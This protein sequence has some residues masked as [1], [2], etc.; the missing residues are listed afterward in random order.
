ML[1]LEIADRK[2]V[3]LETHP[4]KIQPNK[5]NIFLFIEILDEMRMKLYMLN[6]SMLRWI[7]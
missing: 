1:R 5:Q 2:F 6:L 4:T 7:S 3:L